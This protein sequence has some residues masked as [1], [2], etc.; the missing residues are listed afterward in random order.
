MTI[1]QNARKSAEGG[2]QFGLTG[3]TGDELSPARKHGTHRHAVG[4]CGRVLRYTSRGRV[5]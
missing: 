2:A 3:K 1:A 5:E 4:N